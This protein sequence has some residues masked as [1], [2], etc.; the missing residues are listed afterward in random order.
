V[1]AKV[2]GEVARTA[3]DFRRPLPLVQSAAARIVPAAA[4]LEI[5]EPVVAHVRIAVMDLER[6]VAARARGRA[7]VGV[8]ASVAVTLGEPVAQ[9]ADGAAVGAV[10]VAFR[11]D[12]V[13]AAFAFSD[14]HA[15]A[16]GR[17]A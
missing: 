10:G 14:G 5:L 1:L 15:G 4:E 17:R 16:A 11:P 9:L 3:E 7:R 8:P 6:E 2:V 12:E 13:L